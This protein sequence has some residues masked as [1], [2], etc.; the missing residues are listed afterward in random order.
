MN[1]LNEQLFKAVKS[2]E[3]EEVKKLIDAGA[4]VNVVNVDGETALYW[5]SYKGR[6]EIVKM[7]IEAG[8]DVNVVNKNHTKIED[9]INKILVN[10]YRIEIE[11]CLTI[12]N[13]VKITTLGKDINCFLYN[14]NVSFEEQKD[15]CKLAI[16]KLSQKK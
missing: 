9:I 13:L 6:S 7:L 10:N 11:K 2:N 5:A 3:I 8:A 1:N 16:E 12:P 15:D 14:L 4:D